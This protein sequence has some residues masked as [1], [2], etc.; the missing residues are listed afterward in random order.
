VAELASPSDVGPRCVSPLQCKRKPYGANGA[1]LD[2]QLLPHM[3]VVEVWPASGEPQRLEQIQVLKAPAEC[4]GPQL[5][6]SE[7][8]PG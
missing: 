1:H 4:P 8:R 2:W 3:Q 7:I 5:H 6:L